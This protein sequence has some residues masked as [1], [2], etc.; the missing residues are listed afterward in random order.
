MKPVRGN[1][2]AQAGDYL[3]LT[4]PEQSMD[5]SYILVVSRKIFSVALVIWFL[6]IN[7]ILD[8]WILKPNMDVLFDTAARIY[9]IRTVIF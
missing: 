1:Q 2:S 5:T 7:V 9:K 3:T 4:Q 8:S 6:Q